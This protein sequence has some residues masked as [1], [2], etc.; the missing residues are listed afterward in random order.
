MVKGFSCLEMVV[1]LASSRIL[2]IAKSQ[3]PITRVMRWCDLDQILRR[4]KKQAQTETEFSA[5]KGQNS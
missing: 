5:Q 2:A 1:F 3:A 4:F